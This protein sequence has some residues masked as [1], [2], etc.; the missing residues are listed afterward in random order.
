MEV[1]DV[2]LVPGVSVNF[3]GKDLQI[4]LGREVIPEEERAADKLF[5]IN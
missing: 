2:F 1:E 4:Q 5:E 3:L